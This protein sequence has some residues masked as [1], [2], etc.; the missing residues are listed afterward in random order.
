MVRDVGDQQYLE[1]RVYD[2]VTD[3]PALIDATVA[4]SVTDPSGAI[5]SPSVMH[6]STGVYRANFTLASAGV[7]YWRWT[8]SG[9]VTDIEDGEVTAANPGPAIYA[10]LDDLRDRL[11]ITSSTDTADNQ[12]MLDRLAAASR[13]VDRDTGRRHGFW[14]DKTATARTFRPTHGELLIVD[15]MAVAP[16]SVAIG[17]GTSYTTI[18]SAFYDFLP[19][20]ALAD[21]RALEVIRYI[22]GCWPTDGITRVQVTARWGWPSIPDE[23]HEATLLLAARLFRRKDSPEGVRGFSDL[24]VIRVGRYDPDYSALIDPYIRPAL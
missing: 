19:E 9:T 10:S 16:T 20:N 3:P 21:G 24:G 1:H 23:I 8:V 5:T 18:S 22:N 14:A 4:L 11:R 15:D 2:P 7:W 6:A 12:E 17:S 13:R